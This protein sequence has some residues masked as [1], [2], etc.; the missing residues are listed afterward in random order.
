MRACTLTFAAVFATLSVAHPDAPADERRAEEKTYDAIAIP[1]V[2]FNTDQGFGYGAVGGAYFYAPGY[3][4]YRHAIGLQVFAT[5]T[6]VQN[7]YLRYDGPR[8]LGP[9]RLEAR[10]EY[11]RELQAPFFGAGNLS[12]PEFDGDLRDPRFNYDRF[13]P[14]LWVRLRGRPW[15]DDSPFEVYGGLAYRVTTVGTEDG[16]MLQELR[17]R[18]VDGGQTSQLLLGVIWDTRDDEADATTGGSEEL[19]IRASARGVLSGYSYVG[20]TAVER[21]YFALTERLVFAQRVFFDAL[22]GEVPFFEW[23]NLGGV[24]YAE[25]VGGLSSVR[26]VP[27]NR[28]A[29]NVKLVSN[30]ELRMH[31][32]QFQLLGAPIRY[33]AVT[34]FDIGRVWHPEVED[35]PWHAWHPGFGAGARLARRAAVIRFDWAISPETWRSSV[36][37][38]FGHIF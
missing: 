21:R 17:P 22:F 33:G 2:S 34:F 18:G 8:L 29:G 10:F 19:G 14:G 11:R 35:G 27:R 36:Y 5:T 24:A 20:F 7:H 13:A 6:G 15:G 26:G 38:T 37:V 3:T 32:G 31:L 4:P 28:F 30:T 12:A 9:F 25:G 23:P 1:L 16:S